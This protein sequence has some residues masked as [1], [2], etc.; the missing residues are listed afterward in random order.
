MYHQGRR[1]DGV[2]GGCQATW[3]PVPNLRTYDRVVEEVFIEIIE[4]VIGHLR[5][6]WLLS[7]Q[8]SAR[9]DGVAGGCQ[10][11]AVAAYDRVVE[12]VF[13]EIIE[14]AGHLRCAWVL[15]SQCRHR[16]VFLDCY[17]RRQ[18]SQHFWGVTRSGQID[19]RWSQPLCWPCFW[20]WS[21]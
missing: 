16:A 3:T 19:R 20:S 5:C 10:A 15:S 17:Q 9:V 21:I 8:I 6:R 1:V 11:S 12:E 2:A 4:V 13:I 14:T 18:W 7:S